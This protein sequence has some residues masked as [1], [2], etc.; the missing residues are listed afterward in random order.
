MKR[1]ILALLSFV[2]VLGSLTTVEAASK[3]SSEYQN[4]YEQLSGNDSKFYKLIFAKYS[5]ESRYSYN[6]RINLHFGLSSLGFI[7]N[8]Q[9]P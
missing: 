1:Q 4:M 5:T 9:D 7:F 2:I 6:R 8:L 3:L